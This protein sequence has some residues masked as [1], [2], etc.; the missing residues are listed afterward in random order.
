M[1]TPRQIAAAIGSA[2]GEPIEF[3]EQTRE[4]A[5]AQMLTFM[6]EP[7]VDGTLAILGAPNERELRISPDV[8]G[9]LGRRPNPFS[10]WAERNVAAFR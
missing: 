10:A 5:R 7:V 2:L 4:Q 9:V 6:P 1:V 8:E 3:V